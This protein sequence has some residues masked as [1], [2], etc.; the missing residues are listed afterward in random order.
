MADDSTDQERSDPDHRGRIQAQGGGT[1]KS[2]SWAQSTPPTESEMLQMCDNLD[3]QLTDR[4]K[5]ERAQPM[6]QLR[7]FIHSA[8]QGGGVSASIR[9]SWLKRG[10]KDVRID[11]EVIKGMACVPDSGSE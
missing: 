5:R 3:T 4:E 7:R 6:A 11:L 1:E 10:S 2:E 9:K 8:A